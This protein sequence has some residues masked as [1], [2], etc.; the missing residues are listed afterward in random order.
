MRDKSKEELIKKID[1][2]NKAFDELK[3]KENLYRRVIDSSP[4]AII[5]HSYRKIVFIN[6]SALQLFNFEEENEMVGRN[7]IELICP[8]FRD[9]MVERMER[10]IN[11]REE[12]S[13][14]EVEVLV[15]K[16]ETKWVEIFDSYVEFNDNPSII[17]IILD[18]TEKKITEEKFTRLFTSIF[19][20]VYESTPD[21]RLLTVNPALVKM[22]GYDSAEELL[23]KPIKELFFNP[24]EREDLVQKIEKNGELRNFE[25]KLKRKNGSILYVLDN[26]RA[27]RDRKGKVISYEGTLTDITKRKTAEERL[28]MSYEKLKKIVESVINAMVK[29]VETKDPYTA[30]HERHVAKLASEIAREL[31]F[32]DEKIEEIR[33][34]AL[35][36]DIGK[37]FI[38]SEILVKPGK[39]TEEEFAFIKLHTYHGYEILKTIDFPWEVAPVVLQHHERFDGSGYPQRLKG[40]EILMEAKILSV[41]DVV[42]AIT[43]HRPYRP[44]HGV[45]KAIQEIYQFRGTLYDP[46]VVDACL[47]LFREKNFKFESTNN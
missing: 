19:D 45:E 42:E 36:H 35:I 5:I 43:F 6:K 47:K 32:P 17:S 31:G 26:S 44:G 9:S 10:L 40:D 11:K 20:G 4:F 18:I 22:L 29:M 37:M 25:L 13:P 30:G 16:G 1:D 41:A 12:R 3:R 38:P 46:D 27:K 7:F 28:K 34:T 21:G 15:G 14:V 8:N 39:L 23:S 2:L 24:E 33:M